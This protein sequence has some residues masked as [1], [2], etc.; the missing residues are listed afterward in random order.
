MII[1]PIVVFLVQSSWGF[2]EDAYYPMDTPDSYVYN[3]DS[4]DNDVLHPL[5]RRNSNNNFLRF[6][7][8]ENRLDQEYEDYDDLARPT[9]SG[10]EDKNEL[11]L[12]FGRNKQNFLRFGRDPSNSNTNNYPRIPRDRF[13]R[14]GRSTEEEKKRSKRDTSGAGEPEE[15]KRAGTGNFIRFGRDPL[16]FL[17]SPTA[18]TDNSRVEI[19]DLMDKLKLIHNSPLIRLL[20]ELAVTRQENK[21]C[22]S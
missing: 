3:E 2:L 20:S 18:E 13:L 7:R 12:R 8:G 15:Y 21:K 5:Q 19:Q 14:Y 4:L 17:A 9:R 1:F 6:G 22:S 16:S 11:F 10:K